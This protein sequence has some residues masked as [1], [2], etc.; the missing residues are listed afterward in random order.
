VAVEAAVRGFDYHARVVPK[1]A[2]LLRESERVNQQALAA[3]H[4]LRAQ[5]EYTG[6]RRSQMTTAEQS[7]YIKKHGGERY[8]DL[9]E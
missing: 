7:A 2:T 6:L 4:Q 1:A 9:P 5:G 3:V 8:L